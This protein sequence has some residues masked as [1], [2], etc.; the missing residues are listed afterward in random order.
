M[1]IETVSFVT[2]LAAFAGGAVLS[3]TPCVYPLVPV[4]IA[5]IGA[6][7]ES[8]GK[9]NVILAFIYVLGMALTFALLGA[10]AAAAGSLFGSLRASPAVNL[11]FGNLLILF[12][13][14]VLGAVE[15]PGPSLRRAGA[16]KIFRG[17]G[18]PA[19]FLMGLASGFIGAPCVGPVLG[20]ILLFTA[21]TGSLAH[22]F[23]LLFV[24]A[25]G[26]GLLLLAAGAFAGV[27]KGLAGSARMMLA[28]QKILGAGML[29]LAQYFIFS[30]GRYY[31]GGWF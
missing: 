18:R 30:A 1:D 27:L 5:V 22:G 20:A 13:L 12:A 4:V 23:G 31:T 25:L 7:G 21:S 6:S 19:V 29:L 14:S 26:L 15:L 28:A 2:Y 10:A 16:G 9:R 11:V 17:G 3:F 24:F 8:S